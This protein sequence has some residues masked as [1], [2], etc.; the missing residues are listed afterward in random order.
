M[1]SA[2]PEAI[3]R[4]G[5]CSC[6]HG[7]VLSGERMMELAARCDAE[8][9]EDPVEVGS[10]RPRREDRQ[11]VHRAQRRDADPR[12]DDLVSADIAASQQYRMTTVRYGRKTSPNGA[13]RQLA[14]RPDAPRVLILTTITRPDSREAG[15]IGAQ[16]VAQRSGL[17][18][19]RR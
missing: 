10:D 17:A 7:R 12:S 1:D 13:T 5:S 6:R 9:G 14:S 2:E 19:P 18:M 16:D 8:L 3:G 15:D 11:W 4:R